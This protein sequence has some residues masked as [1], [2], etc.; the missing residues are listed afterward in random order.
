MSPSAGVSMVVLATQVLELLQQFC[1]AGD[2][3]GRLVDVLS[4]S[5]SLSHPALVNNDVLYS[6]VLSNDRP[7]VLVPQLCGMLSFADESVAI[8]LPV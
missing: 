4:V 2:E 3:D 7:G 5:S 6:R 1:C 8:V